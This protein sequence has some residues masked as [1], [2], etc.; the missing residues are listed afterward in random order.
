[1]LHIEK[2][3]SGGST[4]TWEITGLTDA[5]LSELNSMDFREMKQKALDIADTREHDHPV[6]NLGTV[7]HNGYGV[8]N[9][10]IRGKVL[11]VEVGK[12]C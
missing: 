9:T 7:W 12:N 2:V 6:K 10:Y 3:Y 4:D 1:M 8:Y 5:E 11:C